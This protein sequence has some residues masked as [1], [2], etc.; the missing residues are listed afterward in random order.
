MNVLN[1]SET[2]K[3][4][5]YKYDCNKTIEYSYLHLE[6]SN[7]KLIKKAIIRI[8]DAPTIN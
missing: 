3:E 2:S 8:N 4:V 7:S 5:A 6:N 1:D